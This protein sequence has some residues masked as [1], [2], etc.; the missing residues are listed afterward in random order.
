MVY[1][2]RFANEMVASRRSISGDKN[3]DTA[4]QVEI[5]LFDFCELELGAKLGSGSFCDVYE[6][7][8]FNDKYS[9]Q[10]QQCRRN[11][12][13]PRRLSSGQK[14]SR[15]LLMKLQHS[16]DFAVK[17]IQ[18][19]LNHDAQGFRDA[20]SDMATESDIL[21]TLHHPHIVK[22]RG[23]AMGGPNA[24][25]CYGPKQHEGYFLIMDRVEE[26]LE[27]RLK[28]WKLRSKH[29][30]NLMM[31]N[32]MDPTGRKKQDFLLERLRAAHDLASALEYVHERNVIYRDLKPA[33]CGFDSRND[34]KLFDFGLSRDL[35]VHDG[36]SCC[37]DEVFQMS[38][39][40]G[41]IRYMANEV[42]KHRPYN[43]KADVY[44]FAHLL[45]EMMSL[46]KPYATMRT[47]QHRL[48]VI[49]QGMRPEL[50]PSWPKEVCDL[51]SR[52]WD[53]NMCRRPSMCEIRLTLKEII[54]SLDQSQ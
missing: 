9:E 42:A 34:I 50:N 7:K 26:T 49:E 16:S 6:V 45:W 27:D 29:F 2:L 54:N 32:L 39:R 25:H 17:F 15:D 12:K 43:Q 23:W 13:I 11:N 47:S 37:I 33:N 51:L 30:D 40:V 20:A 4:T 31:N 5:A 28:K 38:G 3:K 19:K 36:D 24:F 18:Q 52:A 14:R 1:N 41:T 46:E 44:S 53:P 35:P 22:V 8:R 48:C 21:A 10:Q